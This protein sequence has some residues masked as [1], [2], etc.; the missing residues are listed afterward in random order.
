MRA[1]LAR[2]PEIAYASLSVAATSLL[3][4]VVLRLWNATLG[5]PFW[6]GGD[7]YL[8]LAQVKGVLDNGWVLNN[9]ALGA[10]FGQDLHDFAANREILHVAF[11]K[12]LG[13][14]SSNPGAV[15]NVYFL[16]SFPLAGL[17]AFL[18]LRRLGISRPTAV[19]MSVL[20]A[21][22]PYHFRHQTFLFGYYMVPVAAYL[23]LGVYA[24][25]PLFEHRRRALWTLGLCV[26]VA[27]S[28]IYYAAFTVMLLSLIHI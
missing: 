2:H 6:P 14:F 25:T 11:V 16:L 8:V 9:P 26:A 17:T 28:G 23:V 22:T 27:L 1:W 7:G 19:A 10:P 13:L 3:A 5:V 21:L 18:V 12:V 24:G 15:V 4:A 20:Y